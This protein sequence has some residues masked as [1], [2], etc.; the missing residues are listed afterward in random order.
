MARL[1]AGRLDL[2]GRI[3]DRFEGVGRRGDAA[4]YVDLQEVRSVPKIVPCRLAHRVGAVGDDAERRVAHLAGAGRDWAGSTLRI[5]MAA[6][7]RQ[8]KPPETEMG[9][10]HQRSEERRVG[11][12]W[13]RSCRVR[14]TRCH[15]T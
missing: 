7:L 1:L 6:G 3:L 4:R 11:K 5:A 9:T 14:G 10:R 8:P 2:A 15:K 13:V 12:E